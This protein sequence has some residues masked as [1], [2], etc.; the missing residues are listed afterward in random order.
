PPRPLL[1]PERVP[2]PPAPAPRP[3]RGRRRAR[4]A[5]PPAGVPARPAGG[6]GGGAGGPRAAPGLSLAGQRA[7]AGERDGARGG[8]RRG[9]PPAPGLRSLRPHRLRRRR[10]A[11]GADAQRGG[12]GAQAPD[13]RARA[14]GVRLADPRRRAPRPHTAEPPADDA[15]PAAVTRAR[16]EDGPMCRSIKTLHNFEPPATDDEVRA[17]ARQFVRKLS[18]F[19]TPS[20]ANEAA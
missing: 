10:G 11:V 13:D 5:F 8:P 15:P 12:R 18:G 20:K 17:S 2:R 7:R 16:R 1:P 4:R 19:A 3:G 9:R 6:A 14:A